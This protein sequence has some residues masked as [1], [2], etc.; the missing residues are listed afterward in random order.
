MTCV[1]CSLD[2]TPG[3]CLR[4]TYL[5]GPLPELNPEPQ[6]LSDLEQATE[7]QTWPHSSRA[8]SSGRGRSD[9]VPGAALAAT[10]WSPR[11]RGRLLD[12]GPAS[13]RASSEAVMLGRQRPCARSCTG[14]RPRGLAGPLSPWFGLRAASIVTGLF[15]AL[16]VCRVHGTS[17][18][19]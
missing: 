9:G 15:S 8:W 6:N 5:Q 4:L 16:S 7:P 2:P 3:H 13:A 17:R 18:G 11:G 12:K 1:R 14:P 10:E 19:T